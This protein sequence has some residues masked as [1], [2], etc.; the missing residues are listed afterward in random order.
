L[1]A[2]LRAHLAGTDDETYDA[3]VEPLGAVR[4][5][6]GVAARYLARPSSTGR[7]GRG[8][9]RHDWAVAVLAT[10]IRAGGRDLLDRWADAHIRLLVTAQQI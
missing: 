4:T 10:E 3:A 9:I 5:R 8:D 2:R 6:A 1:L 7:R